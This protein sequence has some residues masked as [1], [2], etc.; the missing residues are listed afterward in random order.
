[1]YSYANFQLILNKWI[2]SVGSLMGMYILKKSF[3]ISVHTVFTIII[4][5]LLPTFYGW[6]IYAYEGELAIGAIGFF[7]YGCDVS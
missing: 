5:F 3:K 1:M 7:G 6:T 2:G 4:V